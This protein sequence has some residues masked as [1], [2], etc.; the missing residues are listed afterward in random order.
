MYHYQH[1]IEYHSQQTFDLVT[2][3]SPMTL[4]VY[5][6]S[7]SQDDHQGSLIDRDVKCNSDPAVAYPSL[8]N[9]YHNRVSPQ[10]GSNS[11]TENQWRVTATSLGQRKL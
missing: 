1:G 11:R 4:Y 2:T 6:S 7:T 10:K 9:L 8:V 3:F 5:S